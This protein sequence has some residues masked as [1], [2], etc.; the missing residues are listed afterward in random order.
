MVVEPDSALAD[1]VPAWLRKSG[2]L[3]VA[4]DPRAKPL[5]YIDSE[6]RLNGVEVQLAVA[7]ASLLDLHPVF[8]ADAF[9]AMGSE[10]VAGRFELGASAF[11]LVPQEALPTD[12]VAYLETDVQLV[13]PVG[14]AVEVGSLCGATIAAFEGSRTVEWLDQRSQTCLEQGLPGIEVTALFQDADLGRAVLTGRA[15][16]LLAAAPVSASL[17]KTYPAELE[18]APGAAD[19]TVLVIL[20]APQQGLAELIADAVDELAANGSYEQLLLA[21][22]VAGR[23]PLG[24]AAIRAGETWQQ[25]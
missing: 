14:S 21:F 5:A 4:V 23:E 11:S 3:R 8:T 25:P 17:A 6:G 20:A 18:V 15:D 13:R 1:R 2:T 7:V 12:G 16:A 9:A 24:A 19:P 10:L 22:G